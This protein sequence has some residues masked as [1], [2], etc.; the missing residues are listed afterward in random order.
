[1]NTTLRTLSLVLA[2]GLLAV[3]A[4]PV[5]AVGPPSAVSVAAKSKLPDRCRP[6][7]KHDLQRLQRRMDYQQPNYDAHYASVNHMLDQMVDLIA[8]PDAQDL[9]P[10]M[11]NGAAQY[12]DTMA[13]IIAGDRSDVTRLVNLV[14]KQNKSCF[15]GK[16]QDSFL[17]GMKAVRSAFKDL[18]SA[19]EKALGAAGYL[20]TAQTAKAQQSLNDAQVEVATVE[21][22]FDHGMKRLNALR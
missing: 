17:A 19:Y 21:N 7:Y 12:R 9:I 2:A 11:E 5:W 15:Q 4:A 1:M 18:F 20:T 10:N 16:R 8:D 13:P 3:S 22:Q 6:S 14:Q